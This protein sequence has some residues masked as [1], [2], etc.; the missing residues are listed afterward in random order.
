MSFLRGIFLFALNFRG[1]LLSSVEECL[2]ELQ[3]VHILD[4]RGLPS[5]AC[6]KCLVIR[7]E[8]GLR[9]CPFIKVDKVKWNRC[10]ECA[11]PFQNPP[12]MHAPWLPVVSRNLKINGIKRS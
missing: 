4:W 12:F 5:P 1:R 10:S 3:F 6:C 9:D 8:L 2:G 11:V 7:I